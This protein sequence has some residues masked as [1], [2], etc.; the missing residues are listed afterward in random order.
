[1]IFPLPLPL[2][3]SHTHP[4]PVATVSLFPSFFVAVSHT[5]HLLCHSCRPAL[6]L[7][8]CLGCCE[9]CCFKG[10]R[11]AVSCFLLPFASLL[12]FS[13]NAVLVLLRFSTLL[14]PASCS[15]LAASVGVARRVR[16]LLVPPFTAGGAEH[17]ST[18]CVRSVCGA[19]C[20]CWS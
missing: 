15:S 19:A 7:S 14:C 4:I 8:L 16:L 5:P 17:E 10:T 13:A 9:Q 2:S 20:L 11:L 1:M 12:V 18:L 3:L 6:R